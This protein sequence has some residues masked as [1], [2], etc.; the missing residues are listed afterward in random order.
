M[1]AVDPKRDRDFRSH[2]EAGR[3][4]R[5]AAASQK[6][7][8]AHTCGAR[9]AKQLPVIVTG[10]TWPEDLSDCVLDGRVW[11][12]RAK[13]QIAA[14]KLAEVRA[15]G[16]LV[17]YRR[18]APKIDAALLHQEPKDYAKPMPVLERSSCSISPSEMTAYAGRC[19]KGGRSRTKGLSEFQ[20]ERRTFSDRPLSE[21]EILAGKRHRTGKPPVEDFIER[22]EVKVEMFNPQRAAC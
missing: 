3:Y 7:P 11:P 18:L 6:Q 19:F 12:H 10:A 17:A 4:Q 5:L 9:M 8:N 15:D 20:R 21:E 16:E 22:L 2:G 13:Q 14:G 1:I